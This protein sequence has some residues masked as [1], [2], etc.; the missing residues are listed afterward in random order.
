MKEYC[1]VLSRTKR[2]LQV[3]T[4]MNWTM[5]SEGE[6]MTICSDLFEGIFVKSTDNLVRLWEFEFCEG[7]V[8]EFYFED[9]NFHLHLE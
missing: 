1:G 6:R 2:K 4:N 3:H 8:F 9:H 7:M 5:N